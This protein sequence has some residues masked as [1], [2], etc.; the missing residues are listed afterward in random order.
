AKGRLAA[1]GLTAA[2]RESVRRTVAFLEGEADRLHGWADALIAASA[3]LRADRALLASIPGVGAVTAPA[4]LAELPPVDQFPSAE[5]AAAS[6]GL[7][8]RQY[9]S[10]TTVR[11]RTRLS[12]AGKARLRKAL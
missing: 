9:R 3:R 7:A 2:A 6:A 8:P 11:K 4:I 10:G 12:K 5:Q 1:P